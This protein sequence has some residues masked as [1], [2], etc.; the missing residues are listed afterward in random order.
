MTM[1][2]LQHEQ[3]GRI[4]SREDNHQPEVIVPMEQDTQPILPSVSNYEREI[5][6][7]V[8]SPVEIRNFD[9]RESAALIIQSTRKH[10]QNPS[11]RC[12]KSDVKIEVHKPVHSTVNLLKLSLLGFT[13]M[14]AISVITFFKRGVDQ[15]NTSPLPI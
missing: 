14:I 15:L 12:D 2:V 13:S 3:V 9:G 6:I 4:D 5:G 8:E 7:D 10:L 11:E 1:K